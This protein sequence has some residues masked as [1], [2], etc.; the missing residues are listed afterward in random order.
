ME[1]LGLV[2]GNTVRARHLGRDIIA[3]FRT[4]VGGEVTEYAKLIADAREEALFR[5]MQM[6]EEQGATTVVG[7][8][9]ST[10]MSASGAT[11]IMAF[12]AAVHVE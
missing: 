9:F 7:V 4:I 12:G 3:F 11:E 1:V 6:A 8:R 10:S 5:M 2:R